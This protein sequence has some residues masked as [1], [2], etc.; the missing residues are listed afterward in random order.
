VR[1]DWS[2]A[3]YLK[4]GDE[5]TRAARD[6]LTQ[7]PLIDVQRAVDV[8]CGPGNSTQL[9]TQRYPAADILGLDSSPAMLSAA[10]GLLPQLRF[11]HADARTWIPGT[12]VDLVFANATYQ[13]IPDH[14]EQLPRVLGALHSGAVLAVQMPDN[15][16]E[17]SHRLMKEI[18]QRGPWAQRLKD[19]ARHPLP[20]AAWYYDAL[21]PRCTSVD[22]WHTTYN[23]VL[24]DAAAIVEFVGSTGLR[25]FLDPLSQVERLDFLSE[26]SAA[27]AEAY[28]PLVDGKVLLAFP[29]LFIVAQR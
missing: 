18:A 15:L 21:K 20:T 8:G 28:R 10:R 29:R 14:L 2:P 13:W 5:R 4:F 3:G 12:D 6:L 27:I 9:L 26:Y 7:V 24:S 23:H 25:P 1:S 22:I 16:S 19:A 11:E 17:P